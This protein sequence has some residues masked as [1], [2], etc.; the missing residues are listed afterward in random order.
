MSPN[1][2]NSLTGKGFKMNQQQT[3]PPYLLLGVLLDATRESQRTH[4]QTL[5]FR[6][7]GCRVQGKLEISVSYRQ[8]Y[9]LT[10]KDHPKAALA[11]LASFVQ[12]VRS[13]GLRARAKL[14][15]R[16]PDEDLPF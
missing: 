10:I 14:T 12:E 6:A 3:I 11:G 15:I 5:T 9:L 1:S 2:R 7:I 8:T 4:G 13:Y 16:F